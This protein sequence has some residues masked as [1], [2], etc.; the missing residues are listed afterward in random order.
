MPAHD[1]RDL[2]WQRRYDE[3]DTPW[4]K[5]IAAPPLTQ[6]LES[7][8]ITGR[9]LVPGCGLGHDV[10]ALAAAQPDSFFVGLDLAP[11]AVAGATR[12]AAEANLEP[13]TKFILGDFFKLAPELN[14]TFDWLVEHTC[15]CAIE[16]RLRPDY[17]RAAAEALRPG[18]KIFG[19]FYLIPN[20]ET[21]PPFAVSQDELTAFF[22]PHFT[23]LEHWV[24]TVTFPGRENRELILILQ[25]R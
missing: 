12:L 6:Y 9:V 4:D 18:G 20:V 3:K 21:G 13:C 8:V 1:P 23:I 2:E 5:G 16:P 11:S 10:R 22:S 14:G 25:K 15:F 19:I 24:P 17:V 7:Q